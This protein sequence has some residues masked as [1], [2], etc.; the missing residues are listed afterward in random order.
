MDYGFS[1]RKALVLGASRGLGAASARLLAEEGAQVFAASRK[2]ALPDWAGGLDVIPVAV[3]LTDPA[4]VAAI[5]A[6]MAAEG[7]DILV[8]NCGGPAAGPAA[9]QG[10][11]GWQAAFAAMA[12]PVFALTDAV[13]PGMVARGW[14]R[15]ITIGSSGVIAPIPNLALSNGV[16]GAVAG[17][18]KTLAAEV[19]AKGV[20]VNMVLPGRI[21]TDRVRELDQG[22]AGKSGQTLEQV[23]AESR[24]AIPAGRYGKPE[25]F[26]AVVAFL[27]S[28]QASYVTGSMIRADGGLL[29]NL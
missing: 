10:T 8:N 11:A 20:T 7:I 27:A 6:Q 3:D 21:A 19:A 13:L 9:G 12:T 17:W 1:G 24:A 26:A 22:K 4:A 16:R 23:E 25:E 28:A 2:G 18:S 5:G 29:R 14:G 15:I